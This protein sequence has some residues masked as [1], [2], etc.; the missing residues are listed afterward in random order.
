MKKRIFIII[1]SLFLWSSVFANEN[2]MCK[3][4]VDKPIE[5]SKCVKEKSISIG[6]KGIELGKES[7]KKLNTDSKLTDWLKK[8]REKN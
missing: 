1:S 4:L 7:S 6:K 8:M 5:W 2:K 3:E